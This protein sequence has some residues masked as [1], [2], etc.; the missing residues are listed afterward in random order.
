MHTLQDVSVPAVGWLVMPVGLVL[1]VVSPR[2]LYLSMIFAIPFSATA[3]VNFGASGGMLDSFGI[4]A[5]I[6]LGCVWLARE[7][8]TRIRARDFRLPA[9][10][11]TTALLLLGFLAA[12]TL[13]LVM[14]AIIN[15]H[16]LV[17]TWEGSWSFTPLA[18]P[19][20]PPAFATALPLV[21][22]SRIPLLPP[23]E[24]TVS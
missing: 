22:V 21:S 17:R 6:F 5:A 2:W 16:F 7:V 13:S 1:A 4:Q 10:L 11:R 19:P 9:S 20:L 18:A 15:G 8:V 3:V 14:P 23:P 24:R 12:A